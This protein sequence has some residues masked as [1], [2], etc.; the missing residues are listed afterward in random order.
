MHLRKWALF[1][2]IVVLVDKGNKKLKYIGEAVKKLEELEEV[3]FFS[4]YSELGIEKLKFE[5][6]YASYLDTD[7]KMIEKAAA[8]FFLGST[9]LLGPVTK[10]EFERKTKGVQVSL[11]NPADF[12]IIFNPNILLSSDLFD[13][14]ALFVK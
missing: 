3:K 1:K 10:I 5:R 9:N 6:E 4:A 7:V 2:E 12:A 8:G 14:P 11:T 13:S